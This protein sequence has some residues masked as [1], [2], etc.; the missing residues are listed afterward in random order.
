MSKKVKTTAKPSLDEMVDHVRKIE[1]L[2]YSTQWRETARTMRELRHQF[3]DFDLADSDPLA[4]RFRIAQQ[5]F[6]DRRADFYSRGND[7]KGAGL[8]DKLVALQIKAAELRESIQYC[9]STLKDFQDRRAKLDSSESSDSIEAFIAESCREV[10][11]DIAAKTES[12]QQ[13]EDEMT[14]LTTSYCGP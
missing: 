14:I 6:M 1:E 3:K 2:A 7:R 9:H 10:E 12:L 13:V 5:T 8:S 11:A 4:V